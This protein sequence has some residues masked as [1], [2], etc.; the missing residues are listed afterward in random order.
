MIHMSSLTAFSDRNKRTI[1]ILDSYTPTGRITNPFSDLKTTLVI[2]EYA[3]GRI[4]SI[5][6]LRESCA[7][8]IISTTLKKGQPAYE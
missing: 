7:M 3:P 5:K 1:S 4:V 6:R 8:T 2:E